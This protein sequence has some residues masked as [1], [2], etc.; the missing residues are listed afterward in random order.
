[1]AA[2]DFAADFA[3]LVTQLHGV[4]PVADVLVML[5]ATLAV[6]F[7]LALFDVGVWVYHQFWGSS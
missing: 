2:A 5:A 1:V 6:A 7:V 4:L 3:G